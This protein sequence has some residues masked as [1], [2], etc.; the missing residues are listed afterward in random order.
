MFPTGSSTRISWFSCHY[1]SIHYIKR[2]RQNNFK[3]RK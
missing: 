1:H 2:Q 3:S